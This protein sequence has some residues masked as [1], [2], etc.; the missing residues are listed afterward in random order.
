MI[1]NPYPWTEIDEER[2]NW[3]LN[4]LPPLR[5]NA[6][7]FIN[8]EPYSHRI[9]PETGKEQVHFTYCLIR[10]DPDTGKLRFFER[11]GT[12]QEYEAEYLS[13]KIPQPPDEEPPEPEDPLAHRDPWETDRPQLNSYE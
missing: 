11:V 4:C 13:F 1:R 2:Y 10:T 3:L 12:V 9:N 8:S 6:F 5:H 7:G